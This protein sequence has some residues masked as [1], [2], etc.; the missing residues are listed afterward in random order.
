MERL[1][2]ATDDPARTQN[3]VRVRRN[4]VSVLIPG[5]GALYE[6]SDNWRLL[7]GI[8]RGFN[9]PA[10]GSSA[11]AEDS[12]NIEF[13]ARFHSDQVRFDAIYFHNDYENLVGTV[14]A[15][16][17]GNGQIG[18]QFDGGEVVVQG[19][20]LGGDWTTVVADIEIPLGLQYTWTAEAEFKNGF[21]SGFDPWGDV[22]PGDELPYIP[23]HQFRASAGLTT[24]T[25][26]VNIAAIYVGQMRASAGQGEYTPSESIGSHTVWD[27]VARWNWSDSLSTYFKVDNLFDEV[28]VASRRPAGLRPGLER[29][30]YVGITLNL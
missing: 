27:V 29:T 22:T 10:P 2:F 30:A 8:H 9:P 28:Y 11:A 20:E 15:S 18:D 12:T 7:G 19:L 25:W 4:S 6:L 26:A 24:D 17:G 13:G 1:D 16:T 23:E 21:D 14:T 3:P 5:V